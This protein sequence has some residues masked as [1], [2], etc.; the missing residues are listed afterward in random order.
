M[1]ND[2]PVVDAS[3]EI[4]EPGFY[5]NR[6]SC[7]HTAHGWYEVDSL[8]DHAEVFVNGECYGERRSTATVNL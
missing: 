6:I 5:E 7:T 1:K 3:V 2:E 4:E 8:A